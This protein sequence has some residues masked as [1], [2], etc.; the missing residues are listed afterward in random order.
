M[1]DKERH[2]LVGQVHNPI[3]DSTK[4]TQEHIYKVHALMWLAAEE[5]KRRGLV[6]DASKLLPPEKEYFDRETPL[7]E[8]LEFGSKEYSDSIKRIKPALEH[9]YAHNDHH[10]QFHK[11]KGVSGMNLFSLL[12]MF[13]DWKASG[14]RTKT[15]NIYKSIE[16]NRKRKNINMSEQV[17]EIFI[18]TAKYL[19]YEQVGS[20]GSSNS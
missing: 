19:G 10:P 5:L 20:E 11:E 7:L 2:E 14:E 4:D 12:E 16:I 9:H 8:V 13:F 18:N 1:D 15:G 6:H 17:A 3:Y